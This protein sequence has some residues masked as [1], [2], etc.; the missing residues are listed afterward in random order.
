MDVIK[1]LAVLALFFAFMASISYLAIALV[2]IF[3]V[4]GIIYAMQEAT[5]SPEDEAT[6]DDEDEKR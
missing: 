4:C 1:G 3:C 2:V 6:E 5:A